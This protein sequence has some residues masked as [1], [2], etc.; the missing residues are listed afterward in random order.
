[1]TTFE[2]YRPVPFST[3]DLQHLKEAF[4]DRASHLELDLG[5]T[6]TGIPS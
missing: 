6:D 1:M 5:H 2:T 4:R 3:V